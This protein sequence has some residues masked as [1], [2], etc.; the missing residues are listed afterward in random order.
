MNLNRFEL[1]VAAGC[2]PRAVIAQLGGCRR[3]LGCQIRAVPCRTDLWVRGAGRKV[4]FF[5]QFLEVGGIS[6]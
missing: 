3:A 4:S 5:R 2:K 1:S 6:V